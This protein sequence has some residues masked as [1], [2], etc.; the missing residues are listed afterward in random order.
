MSVVAASGT[1]SA[2]SWCSLEPRDRV[3]RGA[4]VAAG[5]GLFRE[6]AVRDETFLRDP[7][8]QRRCTTGNAAGDGNAPNS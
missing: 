1:P 3:E 4:V 8:V 6:Q 7:R 5:D 2:G